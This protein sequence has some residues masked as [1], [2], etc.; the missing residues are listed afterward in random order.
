MV[1]FGSGVIIS[2]DGYVV[3]ND[4]V[5]EFADRFEVTLYDNKTYNADVVGRDP[6]ADLAVL[7]IDSEESFS[8][9][10]FTDS[11]HVKIGEWVLAVGNPF[12]LASTVTAGIVSAKGRGNIIERENAI[13]DFIQTDAVVNKGNSGGALVN[14]QGDLIGINS[15]IASPDGINGAVDTDQI[16]LGIDQGAS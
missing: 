12:D 2:E 14:T 10:T 16:S 4:H 8:H 13:E 3:T 6:D 15:A 7:K 11:D 1:G 9:I 5:I